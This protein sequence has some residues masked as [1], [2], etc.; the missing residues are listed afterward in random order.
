MAEQSS[1]RIDIDSLAQDDA[2][3]GMPKSMEPARLELELLKKRSPSSALDIRFAL[4]GATFGWENRS[5]CY[6]YRTQ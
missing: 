4:P 3:V 5:R 6:R 2:R 1:E